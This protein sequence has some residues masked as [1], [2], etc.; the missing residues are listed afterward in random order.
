M[1]DDQ[2]PKS[3]K[4][5]LLEIVNTFKAIVLAPKVLYGV[6][7]MYLLEGLVY[8]G[9]LTI[10]AKFLHDSVGLSDPQ[11]GWM[12]GLLTGGITFAMFFLG[13]CLR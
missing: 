9:V 12:L 7:I 2:Q 6:N 4:E 1:S 11:A 3:L 10:L 5:A 13:G 8:F